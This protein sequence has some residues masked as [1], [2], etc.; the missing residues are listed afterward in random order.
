MFRSVGLKTWRLERII[1]TRMKE[2]NIQY[3]RTPLPREEQRQRRYVQIVPAQPQGQPE[4][5]QN[6]R[7]EQLIEQQTKSQTGVLNH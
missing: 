2:D 4:E 3:Y 5:Q 7:S 6:V 1:E